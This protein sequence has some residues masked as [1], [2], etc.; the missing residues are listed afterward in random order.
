MTTSSRAR[1]ALEPLESRLAPAFTWNFADVDGDAV[2]LSISKGTAP[3]AMELSSPG[4][5]FN[6]FQ[7]KRLTLGPD[8]HGAAIRI[9][10]TPQ[11][12]NGDLILDGNG[13]VDVG[14]INATGVDLGKVF[15]DGDL[16]AIDAG[17][18]FRPASACRG[19]SVIS[20][21]RFGTTT[22]APDLQSDFAG[23]LSKLTVRSNIDQA[24]IRVNGTMGRVNV[25]GAIVGGLA[26]GSGSITASEG[27]GRVT[28][29]GAIFG[30]GGVTSGAIACTK[31]IASVRVGGELSGANGASSG[32]IFSAQGSVGPVTIGGA[33]FGNNGVNSGRV[34]A[35]TKLASVTLGG[36]LFGAAAGSGKIHSD[37]DIGPVK[38]G[39]SVWGGDGD[40]SGRIDAG[41]SL[42]RVTIGGSVFG[43]N[44]DQH[45]G[46]GT[47][48]SLGQIR[49]VG[50]MGRV[51]I[52]EDVRGGTGLYSG[53][54]ATGGKL[55][56]VTIGGSLIGGPVPGT[57]AGWIV[58]SGNMGPVEIGRNV[59]GAE[60][61]G[62]MGGGGVIAAGGKLACVTVGGSVIGANSSFTG[63][64]SGERIGA[65]R[66][67]GDLQGGS[68]SDGFVPMFSTGLIQ[69]AGRI[70]RVL[71]GGSI[72]AGADVAPGADLYSSGAI[73]AHADIGAIRVRGNLVGN[74]TNPVLVAAHFQGNFPPRR[75]ADVA[76]KSI[77]V[78]GRVEFASILAGYEVLG[79][80]RAVNA[81]ARIGRVKVGGD[82]I[83][84]NLIA[85]VSAGGDGQFG[86]SDDAKIGGPFVKDL[87]DSSGAISKIGKVIIGGSAY[88]TLDG[89]DSRRF[90]I[91]AQHIGALKIGDTLIPFTKGRGNDLFSNRVA[92]GGTFADDG[93]TFDFHAFEVA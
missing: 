19:L 82:W 45:E 39:G 18:P 75:I 65:V 87:P 46:N 15:V 35:K 48:N 74:P 85:G 10:A 36:S 86:T 43:G 70:A 9:T 58:S 51:T 78:N 49:A 77:A 92:L 76:I 28:V 22:G 2:T 27:L 50:D 52:G 25:G 64:I 26:D 89:Y 16:G 90:G 71:I 21:G 23:R 69:S 3:T 5:P 73:Q 34:F 68:I 53:K 42:K 44:A 11:H 17:N 41:G 24:A 93:M 32:V 59:L 20:L 4:G 80:P 60:A 37:G 6:G 7:I 61:N 91:V 88:G 31:N 83:A 14:Y 55:A 79:E 40:G 30:G 54:I 62:A 81:D 56:G 67:A 29:G 84:S 33:L 47:I 8:F 13:R 63:V 38:I 72:I 57:S 66:I 1:L 12:A